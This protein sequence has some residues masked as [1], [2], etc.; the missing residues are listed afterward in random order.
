M[1]NDLFKLIALD[2]SYFLT[3]TAICIGDI[4]FNETLTVN[5]I[6]GVLLIDISVIIFNRISGCNVINNK[7]TSGIHQDNSG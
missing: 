4:Y 1:I 6:S 3:V 2:L 5:I 7:K